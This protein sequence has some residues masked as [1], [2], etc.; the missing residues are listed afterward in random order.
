MS[1]SKSG[2][3]LGLGIKEK[4][5]KP[6]TQGSQVLDPSWHAAHPCFSGERAPASSLLPRPPRLRAEPPPPPNCPQNRPRTLPL[7]FAAAATIESRA[8][9]PLSRLPPVQIQRPPATAPQH[10][11]ILNLNPTGTFQ[12]VAQPQPLAL[13]KHA[14]GLDRSVPAS[15]PFGRARLSDRRAPPARCAGAPR[16]RHI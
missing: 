6:N 13:S 1:P 7:A 8:D 9:P 11:K 16:W 5:L 12:D 4:T 15:A 14:G 3:N 10:R 2:G